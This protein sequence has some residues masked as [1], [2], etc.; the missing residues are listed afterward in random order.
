MVTRTLLALILVAVASSAAAQTPPTPPAQPTSP[1]SSSFVVARGT[2]TITLAPD[3]AWLNLSVQTRDPKG[4]EAR[5]LAATAMTSVMA[6][7]KSTGLA[8][9]AI[10]TIGYSLNPDYEYPNGRQ[11]LRGFVV[12][13]QLQIRI[14]DIDKVADVIDAATSL[15]LPASSSVS[16]G[17]LRF[18][19]KS[20]KAAERDALR[21]AVEDALASARAMAEGARSTIGRVL[22]I[23][24]GVN[25]SPELYKPMPA[26]M[27]GRAGDVA[28][29]TPIEAGD[30][31]IRAWVSVSVEI[32]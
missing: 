10:K 19:V 31:E 27:A 14:D 5:R 2:A 20:R 3:Q 32:R 28:V 17:G 24:E 7:L 11:R 22:V 16:V 12:N 1:T 15:T 26:M 4:P 6:T 9:D 30:I 29:S 13:N 18:D 23:T 25:D 21:M 8:A